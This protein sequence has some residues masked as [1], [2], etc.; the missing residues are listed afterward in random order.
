MPKK[1]SAQALPFLGIKIPSLYRSKR[2]FLF[3]A[4]S[5]FAVTSANGQ[6]TEITLRYVDGERGR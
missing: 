2:N 6:R 5:R 1:G 4:L 3:S